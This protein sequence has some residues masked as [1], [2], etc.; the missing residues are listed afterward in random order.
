MLLKIATP[1]QSIRIGK[2]ELLPSERVLRLDGRPLDLGA[3][4]FDLLTVLAEQ[5]GRLVSKATLIQRVWQRVIVE[6]N[7]LAAQI[8]SLRRVLGPGA[9]RTVAGFGY[10]LE[11]PVSRLDAGA[12]MAAAPAPAGANP[13]LVPVPMPVTLPKRAWPSR[14]ATLVGRDE[15]LA[16]IEGILGQSNLVTIVGPAGVGKTRLAREILAQHSEEPAA[17]AWVS[18]RAL[19]GIEQVAS[20]VALALDLSLPEGVPGFAAL[21]AALE[22]LPALLVLDNA[23][24][25]ADTLAEPLAQLLLH[26]RSVRILVTSQAPL[27]VP[28]EQVYRLGGLAV[29]DAAGTH[30]DGETWPAMLLFEQ[31]AAA[32][33]R[34]FAPSASN[35][36]Q[37][38]QIC[39]RLDGNPLAIELAAARVPA[40]GLAALIERLDDRFRLLGQLHPG[41]DGQH[42][43]LRAA[44]DWSYRLLSPA[45]SSAFDSLGAFPR[46]FALQTAA[47]CIATAD[48]D[49]TEAI[50]L[51]GRLVDRSLVTVLPV[52]PPRYVLP[53]TARQYAREQL[54]ARGALEGAEERM[55]RTVLQLLDTAFEE[56]AS[57][58]EVIWLHRY[59]PEIDNVRG[60]IDWAA[61]HDAPLAIALYGSAWPLFVESD[62]YTE[63]RARFE[64]TVVLLTDTLPQARLARFWQA[65]ATYHSARQCDR[66]RYA[67]ELAA[68]MHGAGADAR[69]QYH[70]L[71]LLAFNGH[72]DGGAARTA[73]S[74]AQT[75]ADPTWPPRLLAHGALCEGAALMDAGE[76]DG[77]RAACQRAL[78]LALNISERQALAATV[79][80]V[81]LDVV[82]GALQSALQL[83][84]PLALSLQHSGRRETRFELLVLTFS[85]LLLVGEVSAA[86]ATGAELYAL[87]LRLDTSRLY[88]A[89]EAMAYLACLDARRDVAAR[90]LACAERAREQ[91][92]VARRRPSQQR[93]R[94]AAWERLGEARGRVEAARDEALDEAAAC[95]LA[96]GLD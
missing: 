42:G 4:A 26:T 31:R 91:H 82:S 85:A 16:A 84:R 62:L 25:L 22:R 49:T 90:V 65:V 61:A 28:G 92:G 19:T 35:R 39:R 64:Q 43:T 12:Q 27:H 40:L 96:L 20:A 87:A 52:E 7:N 53:E 78:K 45:E 8:A 77:A 13:E 55:A 70:D 50:D 71:M 73:L 51:V 66:A 44:F 69:A 36:R 68:R 47:Q 46:S 72:G 37:V 67:A 75:L 76:W 83:A 6:E 41:T 24:H 60:A 10:R 79:S 74:A 33:D 54:A 14:L 11:L 95:A 32:A 94:E 23:E 5:P 86:R 56:Y 17:A 1:M 89:L 34:G 81:E 80:I 29:P 63:G 15:D 21:G 3:R 93:M 48:I 58:D 30:T 57:L 59:A 2:F 9:I 88:I 38:A 18:L